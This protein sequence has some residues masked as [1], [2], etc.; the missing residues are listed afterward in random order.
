MSILNFG[1]QAVGMEGTEMDKVHE[2]KIKLCNTPK[3]L[4]KKAEDMDLLEQ[5]MTSSVEPAK[6]VSH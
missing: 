2:N 1:L 4:R 3:E 5:A 6:V